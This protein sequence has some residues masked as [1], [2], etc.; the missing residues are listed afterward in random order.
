MREG[1][2]WSED[3]G[4]ALLFAVR[5]TRAFGFGKGDAFSQTRWLFADG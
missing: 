4:P 2:L 5:A 3:G 1:Q